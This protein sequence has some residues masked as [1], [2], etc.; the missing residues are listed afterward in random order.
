MEIAAHQINHPT[1]V[2]DVLDTDKAQLYSYML[3]NLIRQNKSK[4]FE[5]EV[6]LL[7]IPAVHKLAE[8][9]NFYLSDQGDFYQQ[10]SK[11]ELLSFFKSLPNPINS[12]IIDGNK[13]TPPACYLLNFPESKLETLYQDYVLPIDDENDELLTFKA[14]EPIVPINKK[15]FIEIIEL[16]EQH[17]TPQ[18]DIACFLLLEGRIINDV[19][20]EKPQLQD[21]NKSDLLQIFDS[22]NQV[23]NIR[24]EVVH[25]IFTRNDNEF[26]PSA[27]A[28]YIENYMTLIMESTTRRRLYALDFLRRAACNI[29]EKIARSLEAIASHIK[30]TE[31]VGS[32]LFQ[33]LSL[34]S[35]SQEENFQEST[36]RNPSFLIDSNMRPEI[37]INN[38]KR[39]CDC[40]SGYKHGLFSQAQTSDRN[41]EKNTKNDHRSSSATR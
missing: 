23:I 40:Q 28:Q 32:P 6:L 36:Q 35:F 1:I 15:T 41:D 20:L 38:L 17:P 31:P 22:F 4:N 13:Y 16:F 18:S 9:N 37:D 21:T 11:N 12:L 3:R 14:I 27:L 39:L 5:A 24:L 34:L 2:Y 30:A 25:T 10:L 26:F 8:K 33:K 29:N 7:Q 19:L